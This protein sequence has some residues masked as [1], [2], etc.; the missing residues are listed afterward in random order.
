MLKFC[1]IMA[2]DMTVFSSS[3]FIIFRNLESNEIR[4]INEEA[5]EGLQ[6][7]YML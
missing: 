3:V 7:L 5:F 1:E 2:G 4:S 6:S